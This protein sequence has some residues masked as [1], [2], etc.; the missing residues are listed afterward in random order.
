MVK[1]GQEGE[2]EGE[3]LAGT[4]TGQVR[5]AA[6]GEALRCA[7]VVA[8]SEEHGELVAT[9][10]LQGV[11]YLD[12][13]PAGDYDLEVFSPG[14]A[15]KQTAVTVAPGGAHTVDFALDGQTL[16][17]VIHG[18][19]ADVST[20]APLAGVRVDAWVGEDVVATAYTCAEGRYEL[21]GLTA[22]TTT[23][24][25]EFTAAGYETETKQV[26]LEPGE[27]V[28]EDAE[29]V[30]KV[31]APGWVFGVVRDAVTGDTVEGAQVI[32]TRESIG[33]PAYT[34][35]QGEYVILEL[36]AEQYRVSA[37]EECYE[38]Q[39]LQTIVYE[40]QGTQADFH[41]APEGCE[42]E[43]ESEDQSP[44][45]RGCAGGVLTKS[46]PA[47]PTAGLGGDVLVMGLALLA[48]SVAGR[49]RRNCLG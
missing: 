20:G 29:L 1:F 41:L 44:T 43:G 45:F 4:V 31:A 38:R 33:H 27:V 15:V 24:T 40:G 6:T 17:G 7:T 35:A 39:A 21:A 13:L 5:G 3:P 49:K 22:K 11:Y 47:G 14:F 36:E 16:A 12:D 26:D 42:G 48:L 32:A 46:D 18:T 30:L 34:N 25:L 19:V 10:D 28:E 2:G 23:F 8:T 9:T 37:T